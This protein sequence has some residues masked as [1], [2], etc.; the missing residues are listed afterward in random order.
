MGSKSVLLTIAGSDPFGGAGIQADLK[1]AERLGCYGCSVITAL[2]AQNSHGVA[3]IWPVGS[4]IV[5]TQLLSLME[6]IKPDAVKIGM[7][8]DAPTIRVVGNILKHYKVSNIV[9]DPVLTP[10]KGKSLIKESVIEALYEYIFPIATLITPNL[11]ES[12]KLS[13]TVKKDVFHYNTAVLLK[14]GH[15]GSEIIEDILIIN[16]NSSSL[17]E[18]K[19][20]HARIP[21]INTHG[22]GCVLSSAIACGLAKGYSLEEAV[23]DGIRFITSAL[24]SFIDIRLGSGGYGPTLF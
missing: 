5:E 18:K 22:S 10:T 13:D 8:A 14:G 11:P 12:K 2:T 15:S 1:T 3:D 20:S 19:Y 6:D 16:K 4:E 23:E 24:S 17:Q 21:T 9:V 7:I